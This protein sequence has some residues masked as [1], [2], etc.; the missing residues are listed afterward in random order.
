[1]THPALTWAG[2]TA[3]SL[4]DFEML[5]RAAWQGLPETFRTLAGNVVIRVEDFAEDEVLAHFGMESGFDL[6]GLYMGAGVAGEIG[7]DAPPIP[8]VFLYRRPILDE[9][10]ERGDETLE[11]MVRHVLVHEIGHHFG[12]SD[13]DIDRIEAQAA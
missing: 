6:T 5:A 10:A 9:W 3:P 1:M 2:L 4:D 11:H 13:D 8:M 7:T 12:L